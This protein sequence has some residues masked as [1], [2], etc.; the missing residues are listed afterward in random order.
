VV[1]TINSSAAA[2]A[3]FTTD[4]I[5]VISSAI[6]DGEPATSPLIINDRPYTLRVRYPT[7]NRSSLEA[8][9]NTMI[10][11]SNGGT[12]TLGSISTVSEVPGQTE[13][14]RDNLQQEK[15]VTGASRRD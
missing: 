2:K 1:F 12:A 9:G 11:N 6:V 3:G 15:E 5:T 4:Q 7:A 8:M 13:I 14:L 10:V